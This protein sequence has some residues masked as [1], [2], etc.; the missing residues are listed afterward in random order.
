MDVPEEFREKKVNYK[1]PPFI[2]DIRGVVSDK[3]Q[4]GGESIYLI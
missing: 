3:G 2:V 1:V 4:K